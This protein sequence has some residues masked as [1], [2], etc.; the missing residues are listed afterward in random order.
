ML[1]LIKWALIIS[2]CMVIWLIYSYF[3][4][5]NTDEKDLTKRDAIEAIEKED[6]Y[7]FFVPLSEKIKT[8]AIRKKDSF[9]EEVKNKTKAI[10]N[11]IF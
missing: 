1:K 8:E 4:N 6:P 5:I 2:F 9:F 11:K 3:K 7:I 10:I